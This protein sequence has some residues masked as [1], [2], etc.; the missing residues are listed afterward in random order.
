MQIFWYTKDILYDSIAF[1][2]Y[3]NTNLKL[4]GSIDTDYFSAKNEQKSAN[5]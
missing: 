3:L 1:C 2:G 5:R 4:I